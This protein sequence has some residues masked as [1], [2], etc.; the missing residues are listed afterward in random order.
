MRRRTIVLLAGAGAAVVAVPLV[1][2]GVVAWVNRDTPDPAALGE[3]PESAAGGPDSAEGKWVVADVDTNFVGYRIRERLGPLAAPSD[4]VGRTNQV[5]GSVEIGSD[6]GEWQLTALDV[7]VDTASFDSENRSRDGFVRDEALAADEFP[8]AELHLADP[9]A[10]GTPSSG[11]EHDVVD[12]EVPADLTLHGTTHEVTFDV[13][14]RWNGPTIQ[15]AGSTLIHRSDFGID[16]S[17]RAGFNIAEEGT[18]EFE[19]TLTPAGGR[20]GV[21]PPTLVDNPV[22]PTDEGEFRPPCQSDD[23]ALRLDPPVLVSVSAPPAERIDVALVSGALQIDPLLYV[24]PFDGGVAWSP[25]GRRA[26]YSAAPS[27]EDPRTLAIVDAIAGAAPSPIP[28]LQY[29]THPDWGPDGTIVFVQGN[30]E[31]NDSDIWVVRP[32][33]SDAHVLVETPGLDGDPRWSPDGQ[34]VVFFTTDGANNQDVVVVGK[35]GSGLRTLV[36]GTGYEYAPAFTPDGSQVLFV[37]DGAIAAVGVDGTGARQLTD[38]PSDTYPAMSPDGSRIA[39]L[40]KGS[41]FV[42]GA[43]GSQPACVVTNQ[44]IGAGPRWRP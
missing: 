1:A 27:F 5:D 10:L 15:A 21:T 6:D 41:L 14:A 40:R 4:A 30:A 33:G 9:V 37:R 12:V 25:D 43:D 32:D 13:Q 42:A 24:G 38:G 16:V 23:T 28:G 29:A 20:V 31:G 39:F 35:D 7:S 19:L 44:A 36:G 22:I 17:S 11:S 3:A 8:T 18:I 34:S 26:V 2:Y